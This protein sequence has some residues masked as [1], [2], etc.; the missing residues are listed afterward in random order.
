V[1]PIE[2]AKNAAATA[3]SIKSNIGRSRRWKEQFA[4]LVSAS[5]VEAEEIKW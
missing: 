5:T 3:S 2:R 1:Y 4:Q